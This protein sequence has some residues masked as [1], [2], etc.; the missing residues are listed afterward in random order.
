MMLRLLHHVE[1]RSH[2]RHNKLHKPPAPKVIRVF[3]VLVRNYGCNQAVKF[4]AS[5]W[6]QAIKVPVATPRYCQHLVQ[7]SRLLD[8]PKSFIF[9][10]KRLVLESRT[11]EFALLSFRD[12]VFS[13]SAIE[14]IVEQ[15]KFG[16]KCVREGEEQPVSRFTACF[17]GWPSTHHD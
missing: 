16:I 5:L 6:M 14:K 1:K 15:H 10:T 9:N 12:T 7:S 8:D 2:P 17:M 13:E 4:V 11:E 3:F